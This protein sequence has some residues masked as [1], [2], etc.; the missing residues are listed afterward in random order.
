VNTTRTVGL[1]LAAVAAALWLVIVVAVLAV[2]F[3]EGVNIGAAFLAMLAVPLWLAASVVL[4]VSRHLA[5]REGTLQK[6]ATG[7]VAA[8]LA[9]VSAVL[10]PLSMVLGPMDHVVPVQL[11]LG[12]LLGGIAAFIASAVLFLTPDGRRG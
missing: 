5:A 10:L 7:R 8:V 12:S 2:G 1:V 9:L 3:D 4:L 6:T 11:L